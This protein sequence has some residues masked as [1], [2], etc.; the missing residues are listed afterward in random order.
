[1]K[2]TKLDTNL[3]D[4]VAEINTHLHPVKKLFKDYCCGDEFL[5]VSSFYYDSDNIKYCIGVNSTESHYVSDYCHET[6]TYTPRPQ[7]WIHTSW[8]YT[9]RD[10]SEWRTPLDQLI[11][12]PDLADLHILNDG[13]IQV[14]LQ[15][16]ETTSY[17][18]LVMTAAGLQKLKKKYP[19]IH[20]GLTQLEDGNLDQTSRLDGLY[21]HPAISRWNRKMHNGK[22]FTLEDNNIVWW[23]YHHFDDGLHLIPWD[24]NLGHMMPKVQPWSEEDKRYYEYWH[25]ERFRALAHSSLELG[26]RIDV[27]YDLMEPL[28]EKIDLSDLLVETFREIAIR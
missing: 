7:S 24:R 9:S 6:R 27:R 19:D 18:F 2:S 4:I 20:R 25:H 16:R 10:E 26:R 14:E 15:C 21:E 13:M 17:G 5:H 8:E 1:M 3:C 23:M 28:L 12:P 11:L 22:E